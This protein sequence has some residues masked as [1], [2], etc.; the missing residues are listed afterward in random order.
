MARNGFP[1]KTCSMQGYFPNHKMVKGQKHLMAKMRS[2]EDLW[3][4][5]ISQTRLVWVKL[6]FQ[7][8]KGGTGS[9][10]Q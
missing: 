2:E 3:Y 5:S 8:A 4:Q 9:E 10:Y 7:I 6:R 1:K